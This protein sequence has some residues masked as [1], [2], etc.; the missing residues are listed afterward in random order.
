MEYHV[1]WGRL[2]FC[3]MRVTDMGIRQ[4]A[5]RGFTLIELMIVVA[6]V[7][8]LAAIAIPSYQDY[9]V[10]ARVT[11][12]LSMADGAKRSVEDE[13]TVTTSLPLAWVPTSLTNP[14]TN[15]KFVDVDPTSGQVTITFDAPTGPMANQSL[16][17]V[18]TFNGSAGVQWV[19]NTSGS[20]ASNPTLYRY[21]PPNC[22]N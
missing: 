22:R 6:I 10:R 13:W 19:C 2:Q 8:I 14:T 17:L 18:P 21:L 15:V 1:A 12:G 20:G 16:Y 5:V 9:T 7:G 4:A 3:G 11:E